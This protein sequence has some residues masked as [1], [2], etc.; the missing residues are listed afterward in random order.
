MYDPESPIQDADIEMADLQRE[1]GRLARLR[2]L[3]FCG[4]GWVQGPPGP[5]RKPT[6]VWTCL[7][8]GKVFETEAELIED[9]R[10]NTL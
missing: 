4:H 10:E 5:V 3:G 7:D 6:S 2:K 8:C 1:A 9:G